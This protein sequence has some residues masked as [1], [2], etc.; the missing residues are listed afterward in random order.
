MLPRVRK[1]LLE[2]ALVVLVGLPVAGWAA[3]EGDEPAAETARPSVL[4]LTLDSLRPDHLTLEPVPEGGRDTTPE[5]RAF[6]EEAIVFENAFGTSAW[7]SPGIVSILT[8]YLPPVHAQN[9]RWSWYDESLASPIRVLDEAGLTTYGQVLR[10]PNYEGL[11]F[12]SGPRD[13]DFEGFVRARAGDEAPFFAWL[14]SKETHLPYS[15]SAASSG[16][17]TTGLESPGLEAVR[18]F[19]LILRPRD[20][21]VPYENAGKVTFKSQDAGEIR[22]LYD[23]C[24]LDA[25]A[26][27]G[28][29]F[30]ALRETGLLDRTIVVVTS[31]HGEEL[32]EHGWVGHASTGY[33]GK[34]S[35]E[36][37]RVPLIVRLPEGRHAGRVAALV[38]TTDLMPSLFTWLGLDPARVEPAMQGTSLEP[39]LAGEVDS[40][41]DHVFSQTTRKGWTTPQGEMRRRVT[42]VRGAQRK[43][44]WWPDG[45]V[46]AFDLAADPGETRNLWPRELPRFHP[47]IAAREAFDLENDERAAR[48]WTEGAGRIEEQVF[49]DLA[50]GELLAA[51][52]LWRRLRLSQETLALEPASF[53]GSA[54]GDAWKLHRSRV[55]SAVGRALSCDAAGASFNVVTDADGPAVQCAP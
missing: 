1:R 5:L 2:C 6:A 21:D 41:R 7:T 43:V 29:A 23:E 42:A 39:L 28:R 8:G 48:L 54:R 55:G 50:A 44:V 4:L 35:D 51:V 38:Q 10:G 24:V 36:L 40:V 18:G 22:A 32:L 19:K 52:D 46:E 17:F 16:R 31:D 37:I 11:G 14:L 34:L 3:A 45:V 47:E 15:P 33:D 25:D 9:G 49:A 13:L 27:L 20:L 53:L 26:H 12:E 30:A